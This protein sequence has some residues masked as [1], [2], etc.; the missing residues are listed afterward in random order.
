[1]AAISVD[2]KVSATYVAG[3]RD[4]KREKSEKER[5]MYIGC[6]ISERFR[7]LGVHAAWVE[8]ATCEPAII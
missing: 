1:V 7:W 2:R 5:G 6:A 4:V 8:D 3:S